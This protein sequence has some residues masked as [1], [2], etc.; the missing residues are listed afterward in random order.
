MRNGI[1]AIGVLATVVACGASVI[2]RPESR[3]LEHAPQGANLKSLELGRGVYVRRCSGCHRL[4]A[5]A[6]YGAS[7]WPD[8]IRGMAA[9]VKLST[10]EER[11]VGQYL[12]TLSSRER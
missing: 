10:E 8:L 2:P 3:D 11:V 12:M 6:E 9:Y 5:P 4:Y 1:L 7:D